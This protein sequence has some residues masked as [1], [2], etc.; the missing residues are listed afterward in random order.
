[1][2]HELAENYANQ[3]KGESDLAK[4]FEAGYWASTDNWCKKER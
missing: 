2:V 1:M 4:A 3:H